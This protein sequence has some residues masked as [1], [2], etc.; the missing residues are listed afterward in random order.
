MSTAQTTYA[1]GQGLQN[2][3]IYANIIVS[4]SKNI[5]GLPGI[6]SPGSNEPNPDHED[7]WRVRQL[8]EQVLRGEDIFPRNETLATFSPAL[9]D[10][11]ESRARALGEYGRGLVEAQEARSVRGVVGYLDSV[12]HEEN[13]RWFGG[14]GAVTQLSASG[15]QE[16]HF[17]NFLATTLGT[18]QSQLRRAIGS[19]GLLINADLQNPP[20]GPL[21]DHYG[22][23]HVTMTFES[24]ADRGRRTLAHPLAYVALNAEP[25]HEYADVFTGGP[26]RG[27]GNV[28]EVPGALEALMQDA[29]I[30]AEATMAQNR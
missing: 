10:L 4:M 22:A 15:V 7:L 27:E 29:H 11:Y 9:H 6:K 26:F 13:A 21:R 25:G 3:T 2:M 17:L 5:N 12:R 8:G 1:P 14:E 20:M 16:S 28:A 23:R 18:S 24:I 19:R 30:V